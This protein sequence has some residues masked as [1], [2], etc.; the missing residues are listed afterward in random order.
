M[1]KNKNVNAFIS[2]LENKIILDE[3]KLEDFEKQKHNILCLIDYIKNLQVLLMKPDTD[4][5]SIIQC[6]IGNGIYLNGKLNKS[7]KQIIINIGH[8]VYVE[9]SYPEAIDNLLNQAKIID[10]RILLIRKELVKNKSYI[11]LTR[12]INETL[13]KHQLLEG[14]LVQNVDSKKEEGDNGFNI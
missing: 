4:E 9:M 1:E 11:K 2:D 7:N 14:N 10:K 3:K 5:G 6:N 13:V 12:G 8:D